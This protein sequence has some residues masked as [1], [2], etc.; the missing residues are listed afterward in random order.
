MTLKKCHNLWKTCLEAEEIK[1]SAG[2][3]RA[4]TAASAVKTLTALPG[5]HGEKGL[6]V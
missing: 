4:T 3:P 5:Y 6:L 1:A 2:F